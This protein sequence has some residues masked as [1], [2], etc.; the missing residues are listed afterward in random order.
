MSMFCPRTRSFH[1]VFDDLWGCI[2]Y[3]HIW[4][5]L[6]FYD[7]KARYRRTVIGPF[8]LTIGTA[9]TV[10]GMGLVWGSIFSV[11]GAE[12]FPYITT[13][14]IFWIFIASFLNEGCYI[15]ISQTAL[16]HNSRI[17]FFVHVMTFISKN[18]IILLHNFLVI[19]A[20]FL[21]CRKGINFQILWFIPGFILLL[22]NSFW[23][24]VV[25]GFL[26]ARYRDV[27]SIVSNLTTL[28]MLFTPIMWKANMLQ[29]KRRL[30]ATLNPFT[31]IVNI[32][33]DPLLGQPP[34]LISYTVAISL[35]IGGS[36]LALVLYKKYV[37]R[38][39]FWI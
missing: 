32:V 27:S 26:G 9:V 1:D 13:G 18:L 3:R 5:V 17:P 34:S 39:V 8:W 23:V 30:L 29:G 10:F 16:I 25:L 15:F 11:D 6:S 20:V 19:V 4:L 35:F 38:I 33:R 36:L 37:H 21:F 2:A 31:H 22:L 28:L 24:G 12:F 14:L 7:I